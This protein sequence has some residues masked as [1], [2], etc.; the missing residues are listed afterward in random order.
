M[1][2]SEKKI[3]LLMYALTLKDRQNKNKN[4]LDKWLFKGFKKIKKQQ[5]LEYWMNRLNT[6][7]NEADLELYKEV[8]LS[9]ERTNFNNI[10][11][12]ENKVKL[13]IDGIAPENLPRLL[14]SNLIAE[15]A[16]KAYNRF[17]K[18]IL[19][20]FSKFLDIPAKEIEIIS[21]NAKIKDK[22]LL[23]F[24]E[25]KIEKAVA[26]KIQPA[27]DKSLGVEIDENEDIDEQVS[28]WGMVKSAGKAALKS[29]KS[30][31]KTVTDAQYE[32]RTNICKSCEFWKK[33]A[34]GGTGQCTKCGCS[35]K[36][37]LKLATEKCP[38][39]KWLPTV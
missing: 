33:E 26:Q 8:V 15:E 7:K 34:F 14:F 17:S 19:S 1:E 38:I 18:Y 29:A 37:K 25:N 5:L 27:I 6:S 23:E 3:K 10:I 31:F 30:G 28:A 21:F 32:E 12:P 9:Y 4:T 2:I 20:H 24:L 11:N 16:T 39:D 36:I 22:N 13:R 35:T